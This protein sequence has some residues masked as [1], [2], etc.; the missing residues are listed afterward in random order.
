MKHALSL[1]TLLVTLI[2]INGCSGDCG[3]TPVYIDEAPLP[4]VGILSVALDNAVHLNWIENQEA[5]LAGYDIF[6]SD[7]YDGRYEFIG[8]SRTPAFTDRGA[9]N[10]LTNYYAVTAFDQAGNESE[11]SRDVVYRT[12]RPE[13]MGVMLTDRFVDPNRAG[14]SFTNYRIVHFD[15]DETDFFFETTNQG[16]PYIVVWDDTDLQ[17]MGYTASFDEISQAP[18]M[19]WLPSRDAQVVVGHTYVI[20]TWDTHYAKIRV[21][22]VSGRRMTFDWSYQVAPGNTDLFVG[23]GSRLSKRTERTRGR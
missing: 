22:D 14:Y 11:L 12:P 19:G 21:T 8:T 4:P 16:V 13:G 1:S 23:N 15:T 9:R 18:T 17:D 20:R 10:G 5:D 2:L 3:T 6:V 7:R